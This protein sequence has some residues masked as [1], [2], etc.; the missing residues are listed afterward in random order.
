MDIGQLTGLVGVI[1]GTTMLIIPIAGLTLRFA[2]KPSV[3]SV[4]KAMGQAR[5]RSDSK[6]DQRVMLLEERMDEFQETLSRLVDALEFDQ[7]L[8]VRE[9][10]ALSTDSGS[11]QSS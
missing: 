3:E 11:S 2:I 4:V 5:G 10:R 8:E 7:Q 9:R 6:T 1:M